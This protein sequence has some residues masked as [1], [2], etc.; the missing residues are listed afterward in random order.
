[1]ADMFTVSRQE[2]TRPV[3]VDFEKNLRREFGNPKADR[4]GRVKQPGD[5]AMVKVLSRT[6]YKPVIVAAI[7]QLGNALLI[8]VAPVVIM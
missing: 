3:Y 5:W 1:M 7:L 2:A 8:F 6:F 4:D